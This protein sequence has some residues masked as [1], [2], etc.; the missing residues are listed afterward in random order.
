LGDVLLAAHVPSFLRAVDPGRRVL[1]ATK[2]RYAGAL[3]GHPDIDRFYTLRD[4][5]SDPSEPAPFGFSG[6]LGDLVAALRHEAIA[7]VIDLHQNLRS[8]RIVGAFDQAKRTLPPKHGFRRR[9]MVHARWWRVRP[10][11]PLLETY[12]SL[13]GLPPDA[14]LRPWLRDAL[15]EGERSRARARLEAHGPRDFVFLGVGARWETKRWPA[16]HFVAL[17]ASIASELGMGVRYA[18]DPAERELEAEFRRLLP[19]ER[20]AEI[21]SLGF[22]EAAALAASASVIVS[23]DS[24]LLH[25]GPALGVPALGIFGSTVPAFGF[26]PQG[27]RDVVVEIPLGCRPC[28]VHGKRR[29]RS[30]PRVHGGASLRA[31]ARFAPAVGRFRRGRMTRLLITHADPRHWRG[32]S[33]C[34]S[35]DRSHGSGSRAGDATADVWFC[36]GLPPRTPSHSRRCVGFRAAG[37]ASR[38]G[39]AVPSGATASR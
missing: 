36:A 27:R 31:G 24:A 11:P 5:T 19:E 10:V 23:N 38:R 39:Q 22:R 7:E 15:T 28:D 3:R 14:P 17:G 21:A 12:R 6:A 4:G 32:R 30:P 25:L 2:E 9:L 20:H 35:T 16:R 34:C 37:R 26:A 1:F 13:A 29:C 8:S 18:M 33:R